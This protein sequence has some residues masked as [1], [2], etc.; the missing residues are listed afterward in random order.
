[1]NCTTSR[2]SSFFAIDL[3]EEDATQYRSGEREFNAN[4]FYE[5]PAIEAPGIPTVLRLLINDTSRNNQTE[6]IC[7]RTMD[8]TLIVFGKCNYEIIGKFN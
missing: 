6:I 8:T 1:M 5:L 3:P 2:S 4:G 7:S